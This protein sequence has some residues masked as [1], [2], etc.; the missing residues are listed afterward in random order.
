LKA[1]GIELTWFFCFKLLWGGHPR[2]KGAIQINSPGR[3]GGQKPGFFAKIFRYK[4]QKRQKT[5]VVKVLMRK[6]RS[7]K[8]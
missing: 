6:S 5:K 1:T 8:S 2:P 7:R 4:P 3:T